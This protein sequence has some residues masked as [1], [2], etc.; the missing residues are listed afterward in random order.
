MPRNSTTLKVDGYEISATF[1]ETRNT[2][3]SGQLKQILLASFANSSPKSGSGDIL[4]MPPEQRYNK[5]GGRHHVPLK[6]HR[7][8][9]DPYLHIGPLTI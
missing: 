7:L 4:V 3:I 5:D 2:A 9:I 1:T 6:L 8:R